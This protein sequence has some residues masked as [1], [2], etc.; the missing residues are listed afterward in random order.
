MA[1]TKDFVYYY[2][3]FKNDKVYRKTVNKL[4]SLFKKHDVK[5]VLDIG[6]GTN[7]FTVFL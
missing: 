3:I 6:C 4:V 5:T 2:D 1:Y 7:L